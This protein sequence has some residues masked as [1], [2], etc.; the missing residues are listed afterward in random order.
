MDCGEGAQSSFVRY[1][2][3]LNRE[4]LV[5]I[6]HLHGDHVNGL[7]GLLQT[8]GMSQR[9]RTLT[10]VAPRE[11]F[12]WLKNTMEVLHIGLTFDVRF[13]PVRSGTSCT[14]AADFRIR[15]ARAEHSIEAWSYIF[16]ELPRPGVFDPKKALALGIP[17]GRK[18]SSLQH[19]QDRDREG[20]EVPPR[21]GARA[22]E[23]GEE[24]RLLGRHEAHEDAGQVLRRSR[25]PDL[26]LDVRFKG[27]RQGRRKEAQHGGRGGR[28]REGRRREES[29]CSPTSAR[30]TGG[31]TACSREARKIFADTRGR[32]RR[33]DPGDSHRSVGSEPVDQVVGPVAL[34]LHR[35]GAQ[36]EIPSRSC[37][38]RSLPRRRPAC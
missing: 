35:Y 27:R 2:L 18:W 17:R 22:R 14:G 1:G 24:D 29:W 23:A 30:G 7:L 38:A 11:L 5:L 25:P 9:V 15:A 34:D 19:G 13:V 3:G 28:A 10:I 31:P 6:T 26:R 36:R 32:P 16:E 8:M 21:A 33:A 20:E 37:R 12:G 4:M